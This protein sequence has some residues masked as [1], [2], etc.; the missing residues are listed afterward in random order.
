MARHGETTAHSSQDGE[1]AD[2]QQQALVRTR[3]NRSL[4]PGLGDSATV[5]PAREGLAAPQKVKP[6][7]P[8]DPAALL[9][10]W[11]KRSEK[12]HP[13][14]TR[15][16]HVHGH[17]GCVSAGARARGYCSTT[18]RREALTLATRGRAGPEYMT[19]SESRQTQ[20]P[21][22]VRFWLRGMSRTSRSTE[23][24]SG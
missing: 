23:T 3:R 20:G 17:P 5:P 16:T 4:V 21:H 6:Q 14:G 22:G 12:V 13:H 18:T 11:P 19:R 7:L 9:T 2:G 8:R 1:N 24:G 10:V 15:C